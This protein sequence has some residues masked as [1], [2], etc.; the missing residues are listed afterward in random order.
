MWQRLERKFFFLC[1]FVYLFFFFAIRVSRFFLLTFFVIRTFFHPHFSI[2]IRHPQVSGPR[3]TD[4]PWTEPRSVR[5]LCTLEGRPCSPIRWTKLSLHPA[6]WGSVYIPRT[7]GHMHKQLS[8]P[9]L[10]GI[11]S[12]EVQRT[13]L[14]TIL[15]DGSFL[16]TIKIYN[17]IK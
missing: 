15:C 16:Y 17:I 8:M 6:P 9:F 4:T 14:K 5:S 7:S 3:F 10:N 2:R 13:S 1:L 11:E 12:E